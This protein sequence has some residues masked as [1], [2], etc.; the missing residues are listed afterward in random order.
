MTPFHAATCFE[1]CWSNKCADRFPG[2]VVEQKILREFSSCPD[3]YND[4][5][6]IR[7][8]VPGKALQ[9]KKRQRAF[10]F[11]HAGS[12]LPENA[13]RVGYSA[14][15]G[16]IQKRTRSKLIA[17]GF[18]SPEA[19]KQI[20][21]VDGR[22]VARTQRLQRAQVVPIKKMAFETLE[23][24]QGFKRARLRSTKSSMVMYPKS[25][26]DTVA[27]IDSPMFVG[28]VRMKISR[29]GVSWTLSG[30]NQRSVVRQ[31]HRSI[32]TFF[33]RPRAGIGDHPTSAFRRAKLF[34]G[35]LITIT[36]T[37]KRA[38][39]RRNGAAA[40][41]AAVPRDAAPTKRS[42]QAAGSKAC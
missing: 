42:T 11:F 25:F 3:S 24:T 20:P 27:S 7:R 39:K 38:P 13:Q 17:T 41:I 14:Q 40:T 9:A 1:I 6:Q 26:A 4:F 19:G 33:A 22:D 35:R 18:E 28:E 21:A 12:D 31:N 30:G 34:A 36:A 5:F 32:S 23:P 29:V 16:L 10:R 15:C 8:L 2:R 37:G